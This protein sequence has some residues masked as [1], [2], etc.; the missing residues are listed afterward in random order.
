M[1]SW[2]IRNNWKRSKQ[3]ENQTNFIFFGVET[4]KFEY[5]LLNVGLWYIY[6]LKPLLVLVIKTSKRGM[7]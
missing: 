2:K 7:K 6:V 5:T 4:V 3:S 1:K